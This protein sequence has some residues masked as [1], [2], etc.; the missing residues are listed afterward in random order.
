MRYLTIL[1][2]LTAFVVGCSPCKQCR[3]QSPIQARPEPTRAVS[4]QFGY[5]FRAAKETGQWG[6]FKDSQPVGWWD[7]GKQLYWEWSKASKSWGKPIAPPWNVVNHGLVTSELPNAGREKFTVSNGEVVF[8]NVPK[9]EAKKLLIGV[10]LPN[11]KNHLRVTVIDSDEARR[12]RIVEDL[13]KAP[14]LAP[15]RDRV[16]VQDYPPG[17]WTPRTAGLV[18][19]TVPQIVVQSPARR[20]LHRQGDYLDGAAG[21]A[22]ALTRATSV[23]VEQA[24]EPVS[25]EARRTPDPTYQ[26]ALDKDLRKASPFSP[27]AG[28]F[29]FSTIVSALCALCLFLF[30]KG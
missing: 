1:A 3:A 29:P 7:D 21:L 25:I 4:H 17:H 30:P 27:L 20:V 14:E 13:A 19:E 8:E 10:D 24:S 5:E 23:Y 16:V 6:I 12:K 2:A 22:M 26:P 28:K 15:F 18:Y 11:D 9:E